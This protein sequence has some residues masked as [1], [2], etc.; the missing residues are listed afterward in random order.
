M[1]RHVPIYNSFIYALFFCAPFFVTVFFSQLKG[2][3]LG[4]L[5]GFLLLAILY[6]V[7]TK[8][9]LFDRNQ[10]GFILIFF[11]PAFITGFIGLFYGAVTSPLG[12]NYQPYLAGSAGRFVNLVA[13]LSFLIVVCS[14]F[15]SLDS[16]FSR[17][18]FVAN[19]AWFYF[20]ALLIIGLFGYWQLA[21]N[22]LSF[23]PFP[24]ETRSAVHSVSDVQSVGGIV[25]LT[26]IANEPSYLAPLLIDAIVLSILL[27][28]SRIAKLTIGLFVVLLALTFSG[29]GYLNVVVIAVGLIFALTLRG[30]TVFK[31]SPLIMFYFLISCLL[32]AGILFVMYSVG[33]IAVIADRLPHILDIN[34]HSRAYMILM[35]FKWAYESG[36]VN[37]IFG[38]G[39][40]SYALLGEIFTIPSNNEAVHVTSNNA[41]TDIFWELGLV[42]LLS[43]VGYF[44]YVIFVCV[45]PKTMFKEHWVALLITLHLVGSS[46]Y[47]GDFVSPRFF[48][49]IILTLF[50]LRIAKSKALFQK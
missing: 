49:L 9:I 27:L 29:G 33:V 11:I 36:P 47:R 46:L 41:F 48:I 40:K 37:F 25:R 2:A 7:N 14:T 5:Y 1:I 23:V 22:F 44:C 3:P 43:L 26:S 21:S 6:F 19:A 50:L 10:I 15:N 38:H 45:T 18:Q 32:A 4:L 30:V 8:K 39:V 12:L 35:P 13:M 31:A 17:K 16:N 20:Y 42:G 28:N 24:F 34:Q